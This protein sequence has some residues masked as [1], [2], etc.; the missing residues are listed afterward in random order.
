M[1][2]NF[3]RFVLCYTNLRIRTLLLIYSLVSR[4][5]AFTL[6]TVCFG[7]ISL[8]LRS[9]IASHNIVFL[10]VLFFSFSA[11]FYTLIRSVLEYLFFTFHFYFSHQNVFD[12]F[13][14]TNAKRK[15]K[16]WTRTSPKIWMTLWVFLDE[17]C[18]A[19]LWC[20]SLLNVGCFYRVRASATITSNPKSL[21]NVFSVC[22]FFMRFNGNFVYRRWKNNVKRL[23]TF[24]LILS[25]AVYTRENF[26]FIFWSVF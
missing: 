19:R 5:L 4:F 23:N 18:A 20:W 7:N 1:P 6:L 16:K 17:V 9:K 12:C 22:A 21:S 10:S 15:E 14:E 13:C 3:H 26:W 2:K 24:S 8:V 11:L 25:R